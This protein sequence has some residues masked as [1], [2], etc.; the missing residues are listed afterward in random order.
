[1][2]DMLVWEA[3]NAIHQ[4]DFSALQHKAHAE[5]MDPSEF[6]KE[7]SK[8]EAKTEIEYL[9]HLLARQ[10]KNSTIAK[11]GKKHL[12]AIDAKFA[13][14]NL[15]PYS[16]MNKEARESNQSVVEEI[17]NSTPHDADAKLPDRNALKTGE[18]YAYEQIADRQNVKGI[19]AYFK[20]T[21]PD[22]HAKKKAFLLA[23]RD[24]KD[25][26]ERKP[27][28]PPLS[29]A[30]KFYDIV[31]KE[32]KQIFGLKVSELTGDQ[33]LVAEHEY[34]ALTQSWAGALL[35]SLENVAKAEEEKKPEKKEE[36]PRK[37]PVKE[38]SAGQKLYEANVTRLE[39]ACLDQRLF[40]ISDKLGEALE[41]ASSV[42]GA[43]PAES[44]YEKANEI[45]AKAIE[46][47]EAVKAK[48]S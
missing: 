25:S 27:G 23:L 15:P 29:W 21:I 16:K 34:S 44:S 6:G 26:P 39:E 9:E 8:I 1:M 18:L 38:R 4:V 13:E 7:K 12:D 17:F 37:V 32:A 42:L 43:D 11:G 20:D 46:E 3:H 45:L 30:G 28:E 47:L 36:E 41:S 22:E 14:R 24:V 33:R 35:Q 48:M 31:S 19:T 2:A 40:R 10:G 5:R